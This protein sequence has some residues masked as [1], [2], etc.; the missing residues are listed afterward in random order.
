MRSFLWL[1]LSVAL[2]L[3]IYT[4][5]NAEDL[6]R[7]EQDHLGKLVQQFDAFYTHRRT[8][9]LSGE[10]R[11]LQSGDIISPEMP[12]GVPEDFFPDEPSDSFP[13]FDGGGGFPFPGNTRS[14]EGA[15][16]LVAM[17]VL[18]Q[19][20]NFYGVRHYV[21]QDGRRVKFKIVESEEGYFQNLNNLDVAFALREFSRYL[22]AHLCNKPTFENFY[23]AF[24]QVRPEELGFRFKY[25]MAW[26]LLGNSLPREP[27]DVFLMGQRWKA[28]NQILNNVGSINTRQE[29]MQELR[30]W[31]TSLT[32]VMNVLTSL[33]R[34]MCFVDIRPDAKEELRKR[35]VIT[36]LLNMDRELM[37]RYGEIYE[38][39]R[40]EEEKAK[41]SSL[42][43]EN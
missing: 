24:I 16:Y 38:E 21:E 14:Q 5:V 8:Q 7:S 26:A 13:D 29:E 4:K 34:L 19:T 31:L 3:N 41:L 10:R 25:D 20:L 43:N 23:E 22:T 6:T 40:K 18:Y 33:N 9:D 27:N 39:I 42:R 37:Q 15:S 1:S 17:E 2:S 11:G 12:D 32:D 28:L 35:I 30:K 36:K